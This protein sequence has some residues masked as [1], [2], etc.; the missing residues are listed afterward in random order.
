[1]NNRLK[2]I[3]PIL[4]S[5]FFS[6]PAEG[7]IREESQLDGRVKGTVFDPGGAVV[8]GMEI[9]VSGN[10]ASRRVVS[11]ENGKYELVL[12]PGI[13]RIRTEQGIFYTL[14]RAAFQVRPNTT[15]IINISPRQRVLSIALRITPSG[16]QEPA[17]LTEAPKYDTFPPAF[18]GQ[19]D[20]VVEFT[21]KRTRNGITKYSDAKLTYDSLTIDADGL[22]YNA[23]RHLLRARGNVLVDNAGLRRRVDDASVTLGKESPEI[24]FNQK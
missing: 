3:L 1:M 16:L 18:I 2:L 13:Y 5:M 15:T 7:R 19:L 11:S 12:A 8:A 17:T 20:L 14:S 24:K 6:L 21:H 23:R 22:S 10:R 4:A 9:I